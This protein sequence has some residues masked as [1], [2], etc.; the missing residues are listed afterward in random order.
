MN[1]FVPSN[2]STAAIDRSGWRSDTAFDELPTYAMNTS[3]D[4]NPNVVKGDETSTLFVTNRIQS[5]ELGLSRNLHAVARFLGKSSS[6][7]TSFQL[8]FL[9]ES[10]NSTEVIPRH[11]AKRRNTQDLRV[12][13][14]PQ[15]EFGIS[16]TVSTP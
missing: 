4:L 8:E 10:R 11:L 12:D 5:S 9:Y 7:R 3:A 1:I 2:D 13:L 14:H 15:D 6:A 16:G